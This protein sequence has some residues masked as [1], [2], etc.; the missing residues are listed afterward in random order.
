MS[1]LAVL[2]ALLRAAPLALAVWSPAE[3]D[4]MVTA[5]PAP[6]EVGFDASDAG[7]VQALTELLNSADGA[8]GAG[9]APVRL[10]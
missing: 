2:D 4:V 1:A 6:A 7:V 10:T 3:C 8:P 9:S 5:V